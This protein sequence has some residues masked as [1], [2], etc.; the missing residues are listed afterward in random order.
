MNQQLITYLNFFSESSLL[1]SRIRLKPGTKYFYTQTRFLYQKSSIKFNI[2]I[3]LLFLISSFWQ[4]L[5][6]DFLCFWGA[7]SLIKDSVCEKNEICFPEHHIELCSAEMSNPVSLPLLFGWQWWLT[8]SQHLCSLCG[9]SFMV[10][11]RRSV[12][13]PVIIAVSGFLENVFR[14]RVKGLSE[15]WTITCPFRWLAWCDK[16]E[17]WLTG[18]CIHLHA[19]PWATGDLRCG[20]SSAHGD[21]VDCFTFSQLDLRHDDQC[22]PSEA[23]IPLWSCTQG[24][25]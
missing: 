16:F 23:W 6:S 4:N 10:E 24:Y 21:F 1:S 2:N 22:S 12:V 8:T 15:W 9:M 14:S 5:V 20:P 7:S 3:L 19:V 25:E 18:W 11:N 13:Q 17:F